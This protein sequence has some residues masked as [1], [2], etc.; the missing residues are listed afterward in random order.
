MSSRIVEHRSCNSI[1][2]L[3]QRPGISKIQTSAALKARFNSNANPQAS[4]EVAPLA[5]H[6]HGNDKANIVGIP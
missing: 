1:F 6:A 2:S 4:N 5:L 3:G